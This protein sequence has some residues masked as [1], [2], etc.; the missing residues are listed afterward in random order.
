MTVLQLVPRAKE[1][2]ATC[3]GK[4]RCLDCKHEWIAEAPLGATWLECPSCTLH[5][6]RYVYATER[7]GMEWN[8]HCGND[9]FKVTPD[10]YYCPNC[11]DWQR[12]F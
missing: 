8:C 11:G 5:R 7:A 2:E 3:E 1:P 6:G 12:G 9:L 4:A 10:G